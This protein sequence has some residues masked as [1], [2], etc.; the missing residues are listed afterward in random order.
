MQQLRSW[1]EPGDHSSF[2]DVVTAQPPSDHWQ[3]SVLLYSKEFDC[4]AQGDDECNSCSW[5]GV[6]GESAEPRHLRYVRQ[7]SHRC[8]ATTPAKCM[9]KALIDKWLGAR[10]P[11]T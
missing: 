6:A 10:S 2:L 5:V 9:T 4:L 1:L 8:N 7:C 3:K 11:V